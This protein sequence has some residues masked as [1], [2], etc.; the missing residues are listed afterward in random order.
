MT[1]DD[2]MQLNKEDPS[3][4]AERL[5]SEDIKQL[6]E[7]LSEKEDNI[8]YPSLLILQSRS[9][10]KDDVYPYRETFRGKL[11]SDNSL[12]RSI[13]LIM[14]AENAKWDD[15]WLDEVINEF[16]AL[17]NDEKPITVRQ[18]VQYLQKIVTYKPSL[19]GIIADAL[20]ALDLN[21][22]K[23]TMR[24]LVLL[25][26]LGVLAAIRKV[27]TSASIE[28]YINDTMTGGL[29]DKKAKKQIEELLKAQKTPEVL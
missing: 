21:T 9:V 18:C 22:V 10:M 2:L 1:F 3:G 6:V 26:I 11:K 4:T 28:S 14:I 25:D 15:G 23:E 19:H 13:G 16:L 20:I 5:S 29:L 17:I 27:K 7:W 24:K 12:Q 8:R